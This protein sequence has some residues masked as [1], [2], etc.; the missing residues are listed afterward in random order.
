MVGTAEIA[1]LFRISR[2]RVWQ[3]TQRADFPQPA[4]RLKG[5]NV[6]L[7]ADVVKWAQGKGREIHE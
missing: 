7:T 6:W 2:Q 4:A 3:L 1:A 5:S